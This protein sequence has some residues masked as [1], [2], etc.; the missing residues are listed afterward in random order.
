MDIDIRNKN[1]IDKIRKIFYS[2]NNFLELNH[3]ENSLDIISHLTDISFLVN[4][5]DIDNLIL[6]LKKAKEELGVHIKNKFAECDID[7][8]FDI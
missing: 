2:D 6:A 7:F 1:K 8:L 3:E 4:C 5:V